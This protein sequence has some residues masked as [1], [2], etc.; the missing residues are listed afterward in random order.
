MTNAR[1]HR[2]RLKKLLNGAS[3]DVDVLNLAELTPTDSLVCGFLA[4]EC[5]Q[6]RTAGAFKRLR[7][8]VVDLNEL[9]VCLTDE[10]QAMIGERYPRAHR[11]ADRI[12]RSLRDLH[13]RESSVSI[14]HLVEAP[15]SDAAAY[16]LGLEGMLPYAATFACLHGLAHPVIPIDDRLH[17]AL[18]E[19]GIADPR[20]TPDE[21]SD[22]IVDQIEPDQCASVHLK[23]WTWIDSQ[24]PRA[25]AAE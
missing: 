12:R 15:A 8:R 21:I 19:E 25:D 11:R 22:A 13:A 6:S 9:R 5:S 20:A 23:L 16:L 17:G 3:D 24:E 4:W 10:I 2:G 14:D 18:V 1:V 7:E